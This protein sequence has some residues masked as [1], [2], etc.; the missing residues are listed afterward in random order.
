MCHKKTDTLH[1]VIADISFCNVLFS[2]MLHFLARL[3]ISDF[4]GDLVPAERRSVGR[5]NISK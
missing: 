4:L 5:V 3:R 1:I 2:R